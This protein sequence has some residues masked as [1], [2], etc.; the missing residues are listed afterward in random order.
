M[1]AK[2]EPEAAVARQG[3]GDVGAAPL[4][5]LVLAAPHVRDQVGLLTVKHCP[6][7]DGVVERSADLTVIF[8]SSPRLGDVAMRRLRCLVQKGEQTR[9]HL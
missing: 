5:V 3:V 7:H 1:P 9:L 2:L 6:E 8:D 4:L